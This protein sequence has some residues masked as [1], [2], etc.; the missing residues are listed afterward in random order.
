[1]QKNEPPSSKKKVADTVAKKK[2]EPEEAPI[3]VVT[4][5]MAHV[6]KSWL[7]WA[8]QA[9]ALDCNST[10]NAVNCTTAITKQYAFGNFTQSCFSITQSIAKASDSNKTRLQSYMSSVC[11]HEFLKDYSQTLV[12]D[13]QL[14]ADFSQ[15]LVK[16]MPNFTSACTGFFNDGFLARYAQQY[17]G[18]IAA[19]KAEAE[20]AVNQHRVEAEIAKQ[21]SEIEAKEAVARQS[22]E[23]MQNASAEADAK[24]E[25]AMRSTLVAKKKAEESEAAIALQKRLKEEADAAEKES[26]ALKAKAV[27]INQHLGISNATANTSNQ[28]VKASANKTTVEQK[29]KANLNATAGQKHL[30]ISNATTSQQTVTVSL[31]VKQAPANKTTAD[32]KANH[33]MTAK[34]LLNFFQLQL[35]HMAFMPL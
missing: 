10:Q 17:H 22:R 14:C 27:A 19:E 2:H 20:A 28:T 7:D 24:F 34:S 4:Y 29:A 6:G 21:R 13:E 33:F 11:S 12:N 23:G 26:Q 1:M 5:V 3:G 15:H 32:T 31:T 18:L 9:N 8:V 25:E 16:E 35:K 30:R